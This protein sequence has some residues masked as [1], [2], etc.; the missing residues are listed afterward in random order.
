MLSVFE[1][2]SVFFFFLCPPFR[3]V[4][5][6]SDFISDFKC[7]FQVNPRFKKQN[8][9]K[10]AILISGVLMCVLNMRVSMVTTTKTAVYRGLICFVVSI[11]PNDMFT[12]D[13]STFDFLFCH[14]R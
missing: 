10:N 13:P 4:P 6:F 3:P 5:V 11:N 2:L 14:C 8:K 1:C 9:T 12:S 7:S